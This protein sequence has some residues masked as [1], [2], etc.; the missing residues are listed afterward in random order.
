MYRREAYWLKRILFVTSLPG[1]KEIIEEVAVTQL[2][3]CYFSYRGCFPHLRTE[4]HEIWLDNCPEEW[5]QLCREHDLDTDPLLRRARREITPILWRDFAPHEPVW[6]ARARKLGF[7][8]G[9][10][11]PVHGPDGQWGLFSFVKSRGG[12][13][14]EREI[15]AVLAKC[16]LMT[17]FVHEAVERITRTQLF[18]IVNLEQQKESRFWGLT[19]R[20][21]E[22]LDWAAAGNTTPEIATTLQLSGRTVAFH[23]ANARRKLGAVNSSNAI[24]KAISLGLIKS[25]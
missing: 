17:G 21:R 8:T 16:Q 20:E 2:R 1:L 7:A 3:F 4:L 15:R 23:L 24:S 5:R 25:A 11:Q 13:Q 14:A 10:T 18:P 6:V 19:E 9:V 22:C 12:S